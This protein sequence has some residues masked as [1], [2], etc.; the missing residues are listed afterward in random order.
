MDPQKL[1]AKHEISQGNIEQICQLF[2]S[3]I[4][5]N[6]LAKQADVLLESLAIDIAMGAIEMSQENQ[7]AMGDALSARSLVEVLTGCEFSD[8]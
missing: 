3:R 1:L 5:G 2:K 7:A 6:K 4:E 8:A